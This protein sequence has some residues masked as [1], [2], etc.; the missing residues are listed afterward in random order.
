M[1]LR[2]AQISIARLS[3]DEIVVEEVVERVE[4]RSLIWVFVPAFEHHAVVVIGAHS[5]GFRHSVAVF[6]HLED[7]LWMCHTFNEKQQLEQNLM[8]L[9][10]KYSMFGY[11]WNFRDYQR[12]ICSFIFFNID[13]HFSMVS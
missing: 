13:L 10:S 9:D 4:R 1:G 3:V 12:L 6:F 5:L 7:H 8:I 2:F 11:N